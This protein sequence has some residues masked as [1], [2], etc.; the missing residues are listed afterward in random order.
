MNHRKLRITWSICCGILCL[1]LIGLW[2]RSYW[3]WD[4]VAWGIS[5]QQGLLVSSQSGAMTFTY[6]DLNGTE[7]SLVKWQ[8]LTQDSPDTNLLPIGGIEESWAGF[9]FLLGE[10]AVFVVVPYWFLVPLAIAFVAVPWVSWRFS[11]RTLLMALA[12]VALL[13][14]A[15]IYAAR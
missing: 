9:L 6:R 10:D 11:L 13:L 8:V 3:R 5:A 4:N 7:V 1:L 15:L 12:V 14:G 2:V